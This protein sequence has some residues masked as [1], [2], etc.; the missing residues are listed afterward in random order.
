MKE[1]KNITEADFVNGVSALME[2]FQL[3][4]GT[5]PIIIMNSKLGNHLLRVRVDAESSVRI[6]DE[7]NNFESIVGGDQVIFDRDEEFDG[8]EGYQTVDD[9]IKPFIILYHHIEY[10]DMMPDDLIGLI[11]S[12]AVPDNFTF[13][14]GT[15]VRVPLPSFNKETWAFSQVL[16]DAMPESGLFEFQTISYYRM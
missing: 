7:R 11:P 9:D 14:T 1:L 3:K 4:G 12:I 10:L 8:V 5:N 13:L 16:K 6:I 15:Y 2:A